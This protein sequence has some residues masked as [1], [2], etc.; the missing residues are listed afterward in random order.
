MAFHSDAAPAGLALGRVMRW[1]NPH[2]HWFMDGSCGARLEDE[3]LP[4]ITDSA[5]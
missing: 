1:R 4:S 3:D 5:A 2:F